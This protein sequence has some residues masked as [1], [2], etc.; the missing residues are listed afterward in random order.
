VLPHLGVYLHVRRCASGVFRPFS[1][2]SSDPATSIFEA[3]D[4]RAAGIYLCTVDTEDG[5]LI[6]YVG[7]T[8]AEFRQRMCQHWCE[9][10]AEM[11][12]IYDPE[13]F[14][15]GHKHVL[16]RA[17]YGNDREAGLA[18]FVER[19]PMLAPA[20]ADFVRLITVPPRTPDLR[21]ACQNRLCWLS[22]GDRSPTPWE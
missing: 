17:M 15:L 1:W 6:Y 21:K 5:Y 3:A 7:E 8:G 11:Y 12:H 20:L 2:L 14:V 10:L 19:L 9:Q 13:R 18:A 22:R 16:W 4:T